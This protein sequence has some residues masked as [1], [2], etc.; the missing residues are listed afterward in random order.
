MQRNS[1][2]GRQECPPYRIAD[3]GTPFLA[4]AY[5][6]VLCAAFMFISLGA[7]S[8]RVGAQTEADYL[9]CPAD[10]GGYL[11]PLLAVGGRGEIR[12]DGVPTRARTAPTIQA[13]IAFQIEPGTSFTVIGGPACADGYFWWRVA[14]NGQLGWT[15][16][17]SA[18]ER[19]Y[20]FQPAAAVASAPRPAI[21]RESLASLSPLP[22]D[23]PPSRFTLS[24]FTPLAFVRPPDALPALL[25]SDDPTRVRGTLDAGGR[26]VDTAIDAAGAHVAVGMFDNQGSSYSAALYRY[27]PG[28]DPALVP[29]LR[30]QITLA[31]ELPLIAVALQPPYLLTLHGNSEQSAG[32]LLTWAMDTGEL[33]GRIDLPMSP[34]SLVGDSTGL[35]AAVSA[36]GGAG[37]ESLLIDLRTQEIVARA[38]D[39]GVLAWNPYP[40]SGREQ[41]LI[42]RADGI[43]AVYLALPAEAAQPPQIVPERLERLG[44]VEVFVR[45]PDV[46]TSVMSMALDPGGQLLAVGGGSNDTTLPDDFIAS[47]AFIDLETFIVSADSLRDDGWR[48]VEQLGFSSDGTTL[49]VGYVSREGR[50]G[51]RLYGAAAGE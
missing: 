19:I 35:V 8:L 12:A 3:V 32:A 24:P 16:E 9:A 40:G 6:I 28:A 31:D 42:G 30:S 50:A 38:P 2:N 29:A 23:L 27:L 13:Q 34:A 22:F 4:S 15:A 33:V 43:V 51:L 46:A 11:R 5:R 10:L 49:W 37:A 48:A 20:Y 39:Y 45:R 21:T 47:V 1:L 18:E 25:A 36:L 17:S 14:Y 26:I 7:A 41:L 44:E